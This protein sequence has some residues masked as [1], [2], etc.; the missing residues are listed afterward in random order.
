LTILT[1]FNHIFVFNMSIA[2]PEQH[3]VKE[4]L[5]CC[6]GINGKH[7]WFQGS[8]DTGR[9]ACNPGSDVPIPQQQLISKLTEL[10]WL[11]RKIRELISQI[12]GL[13]SVV[14]E[15]L[16]ASVQRETSDYYRYIAIL[17]AQSQARPGGPQGGQLT[18]R[19]LEVWL[20]AEQLHRMRVLATCLETALPLR[21][22][23]ALSALHTLSKHG[24]SIIRRVVKPLLKDALV[25]YLKRISNWVQDGALEDV[26]P[27]DFLVARQPL[28]SAHPGA[29][30]QGGFTVDNQGLP[31]FIS[32]ELAA[33]I[34]TAGRTINF[35]REHCGDT[36][37]TAALGMYDNNNNNN[38]ISGSSSLLHKGPL[39]L[40]WLEESVDEVTTKVGARLLSFVMEQ[41]QLPRH[42]DAIRRYILL[43]QGDFVVSLLDA[44]GIDL[45]KPARGLSPYV[46]EGHMDTALRACGAVFTD[47][48]TIFPRLDVSLTRGME[49]DT[50][51]DIFN[52][53]YKVDGALGAVL[54]LEAMASY[55]RISRLLLAAQRTAHALADAWSKLGN[56]KHALNT[57]DL[58]Q[59]Q[60]GIEVPGMEGVPAV[61]GFIHVCRSE[62]AQ[63]TANLQNYAVFEVIE[64]A[65]K[66]F[67][68]G[69]AVAKD[70]DAIC[71]LHDAFLTTISRGLF[72]NAQSSRSITGVGNVHNE[73]TATLRAALDVM[74]PIKRLADSL[75]AT[76]TEQQLYLDAV[77]RSEAEGSWSDAVYN[78]PQ[79]IPEGMLREVRA[80]VWRVHSAFDRHLKTFLTM[81]PA[82]SDLDLRFFLSRFPL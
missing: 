61:L 74:G 7:I 70:L 20:G 3:L 38:S 2:V 15:A 36:E 28:V 69:L 77:A 49:G 40:A 4:L 67:Q 34:L 79:G 14:H 37:W 12:D 5:H 80:S 27:G 6:Q 26:L 73:L 53:K 1:S 43:G 71:T 52:I 19:R 66:R 21:A 41:Q 13:Q 48:E 65:W 81:L 46:L 76:V 9:F 56:A 23:P 10:G 44:A 57:L 47:S 42:L 62:M 25:P 33:K 17:E 45:D 59:K 18:L 64:P 39:Q 68:T 35:L 63:F 60:H 8:G 31:Q 29:L 16:A 54:H 58:L 82:R 24:D 22:G 55:A 78:S 50:G 30:W 72:L 11:L 51:W 75:Q 32:Q